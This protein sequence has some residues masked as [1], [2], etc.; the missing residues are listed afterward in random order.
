MTAIK[1]RIRITTK[2]QLP[3]K[4]HPNPLGRPEVYQE[5]IGAYICGEISKG[6]T[7]TSIV[8]DPKIP[9]LPTIYTWL[10]ILHPNYKPDFLKSYTIAREIQ[11]EVMADEIK[12][13]ADDG[14]N[15]TYVTINAKG[16]KKVKTDFDHIKRSALRV[17]S[18]KWLAAHLL[19]RKFSDRMQLTGADGKDL[20][21]TI[22]TQVTFNFID[23][24]QDQE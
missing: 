1:K 21:P 7:L 22:P 4:H 8:K 2:K 17:E 11:A 24:K 19:P 15:D 12:D 23:S 13:I 5:K 9:S 3:N 6:R 14:K 16:K 20:I 10:N 18:R